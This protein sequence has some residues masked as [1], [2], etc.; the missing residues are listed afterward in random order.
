MK[1]I[2][3]HEP[4]FFGNEIKH[5]KKCIDTK[6][7]STGGEYVSKFEREI[8][9]FTKAKFAIA[10]NSGTSALD[11]SLKLFNIDIGD[12]VLVPTI[13][14]IAPINSV[15]YQKAKPIFIDCDQSLNID[16]NKINSFLDRHTIYKNGYTINKRTK[17]KI[18]AIIIVHVFGNVVNTLKLKKICKSRNIKILEDA[19]ESLGSFHKNKIH[20]GL[21]GDL[22]CFSFNANKII[23]TGAG[24][25]IITNNKKF[26][27]RALY[28]S[29]QAKDD[30]FNFIHN[31]TGYNYRL[32]N[33]SSAIGY[34]QIKSIFKIM[35]KKKFI[36]KYYKKKLSTFSNIKLIDNS[37]GKSN[38]WI[39]SVI[40]NKKFNKKDL[41]YKFI[42][43]KIDIRPLWYPNHMQKH[44]KQFQKFE[45]NIANK[46][47][48]RIIC[49][50]SGYDL[51]KS[52]IDKI[53]YILKKFD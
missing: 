53:I 10:V 1:K 15:I 12:E 25:M 14:F 40:L 27:R 33:L 43:N 42:K 44:M 19:S 37:S 41:I 30:A 9:K 11:L 20:T 31:E 29:T 52:N 32:N 51:K 24:G 13:T 36:Y 23:T 39:I 26:A 17:K 28:L 38:H 6:W 49:L 48:K 2:I 34:S 22:G 5:V 3:L 18:K 45:I 21:V 16:I 7:V 35:Q 50:P 8:E 47:Y 46:I 4:Y